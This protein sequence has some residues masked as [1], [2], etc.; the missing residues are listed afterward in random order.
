MLL[1]QRARMINIML[2]LCCQE[3]VASI[4]YFMKIDIRRIH[5]LPDKFVRLIHGYSIQG[6][7]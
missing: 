1:H 4:F 6:N 5:H 3:N 2:L 7:N